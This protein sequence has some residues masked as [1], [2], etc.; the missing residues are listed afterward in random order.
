MVATRLPTNAALV[1]SFIS[2][3]PGATKSYTAL[4]RTRQLG[5]TFVRLLHSYVSPEVRNE[6]QSVA[7]LVNASSIGTTWTQC[8]RVE[9]TAIWN[10]S[11]CSFA[12]SDK[13]K[14]NPNHNN[15]HY[16]ERIN[17]ESSLSLRVLI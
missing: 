5:L 6:Y 2:G 17:Q 7:I 12:A 9:R 10:Q 13:K 15:L 14:K 8:G 4:S 11:V 1:H 3:L 16:L